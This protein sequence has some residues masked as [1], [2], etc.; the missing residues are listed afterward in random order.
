MTTELQNLQA[1]VTMDS[2]VIAE[3]TGK[4]H[5]NV[6]IDC[7]KLENYYQSCYSPEKSGELIK[8]TTYKDVTGRQLPC[9][10]LSK[11]AVLDLITGYSLPHRHAV[12]KRWMELEEQV[13]N[14]FYH[15]LP[16]NYS[17]ALIQL[18]EK[19]QEVE[20]LLP[21]AEFYDAVMQTDS[22][23]T[24]GEA[25]KLLGIKGFGRNKLYNFL[26]EEG[27]FQASN[28]PYQAYINRGWFKLVECTYNDKKSN[29]PIVYLKTVVFQ[30]GVDGIRRLI[31]KRNI[32]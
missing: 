7:K 17:E 31:N 2:R 5:D 20:K 10:E 27:I 9:Y 12:N 11:E 29:V 18:A 23:I 28:H 26:R 22:M 21:K 8:S 13:R 32:A 4:R 6:M 3:I 16:K 14:P 1:V 15:M 19:Q 25:A 30:K 24:V